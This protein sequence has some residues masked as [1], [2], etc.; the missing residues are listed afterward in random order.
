MY[1]CEPFDLLRA[2]N[3]QENGDHHQVRTRSGFFQYRC[4]RELPMLSRDFASRPWENHCLHVEDFAFLALSSPVQSCPVQS[5]RAQS[6][7]FQSKP[8]ESNSVRCTA[9]QSN[10]VES[11]QSGPSVQSSHS[12]SIPDFLETSLYLEK[13]VLPK[14]PIAPSGHLLVA[15]LY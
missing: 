14:L 2:T 4:I 13:C 5:C 7:P 8:I 3:A 11:N 15:C 1:V 9:T 12:S 6:T 10:P